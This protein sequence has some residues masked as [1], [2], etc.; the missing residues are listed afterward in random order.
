M[1]NQYGISVAAIAALTAD[2]MREIHSAA[3]RAAALAAATAYGLASTP[4]EC[5]RQVLMSPKLS[6]V[7][8]PPSPPRSAFATGCGERPL[9]V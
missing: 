5:G 2:G 4:A 1:L 7:T 3:D 9:A 6:T 8:V